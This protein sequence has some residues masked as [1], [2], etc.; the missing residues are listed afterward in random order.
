MGGSYAA[1]F[2]LDP[3]RP[4]HPLRLDVFA[5]PAGFWPTF[6]ALLMHLIP[7]AIVV[8]VLL[9]AWRREALSSVLFC[10]LAVGYFVWAWGHF[11]WAAYTF[12]SGP[13]FLI[14][15]LFLFDWLRRPAPISHA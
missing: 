11:D 7:S 5:E 14:G 8:L 12:I 13:L 1:P 15:V 4:R 3:A 2:P 9:I 10:A 6:L